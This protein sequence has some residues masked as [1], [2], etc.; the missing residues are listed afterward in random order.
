MREILERDAFLTNWYAEK[1]LPNSVI[2]RGHPLYRH[3]LRF[4]ALGWNLHE[5]CWRHDKIDAFCVSVSLVRQKPA[6]DQWN[7]FLG[8]GAAPGYAAASARAFAEATWLYRSWHRLYAEVDTRADEPRRH[9][10]RR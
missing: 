7:F 4:A 10:L 8:G 1:P 6:L 2:D 9:F 3:H 5:H